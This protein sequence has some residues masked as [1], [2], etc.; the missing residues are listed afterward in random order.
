MTSNDLFVDTSWYKAIVDSEDEFNKEALKQYEKIR[1]R[2]SF[3]ITT[4]FII[5]ESLTLIRVKC[6]LDIALKF[7]E[8][9]QKM[10]THQKIIRVTQLD[11]KKAWKWFPEKW[12]KLSFTDCIS[13]AVMERL[14]LRN[15][16]TFD[17]H[18]SRAGFNVFES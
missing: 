4:N 13:F 12:N 15:V 3:L 17:N 7:A 8:L 6:G 2:E 9:I 5:D 1:D 14:N 10:A 18:F 11:E 16:L